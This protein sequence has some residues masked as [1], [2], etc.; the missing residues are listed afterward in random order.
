MST[1][2]VIDSTLS[3]RHLA[4]WAIEKYNL[5]TQTTCRLL[6]TN[7]NHTYVVSE[8]ATTYILRVYSY[9]RRTLTDIAE[10]VRLLNLLKESG[11]AVSYPIPDTNNTYIHQIYAPEGI[12]Y[13]VLFSFAN[14]GKIRNLTGELC[15]QIGSTMARMHQVTLG[16]QINR[17]TYTTH[18]LAK[19]AY[20]QAKVYF[21]ESLPD[22]QFIQASANKLDAVFKEAA[23][24]ASRTGVV[25]LDI[26]YDNMSITDDG[27]IT[28]FDFDNCGNGWLIWDIGYFCMQLFHTQPD[29]ADYERKRHLFL[30][31][32]QEITAIPEA[33]IPLI[34]YAGLAIWI[35]YLGVQ[36]ER[37]DNFANIF[38]SEN[39]L[40]MYMGKVKEWLLYHQLTIDLPAV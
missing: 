25:H 18:T 17:I 22:M 34:P 9:N 30:K 8:P 20:Q 28:L 26:W 2:P 23:A 24:S 12:R 39:Y 27:Q 10:E 31:G 40:K 4:V 7:M 14:G 21:P 3:A 15:Y 38:L 16:R 37:F 35:Y 13:A 32:Y 33:E 19:V 5:P 6:R 11:I 1:F 29:K 36:A